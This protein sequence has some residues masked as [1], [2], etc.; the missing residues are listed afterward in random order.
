MLYRWIYD[1]LLVRTDPEIA[2]DVAMNAI[3]VFGRSPLAR[4]SEATVGYRGGGSFSGILSRPVPGRLG[5]AAGQDKDAQAILG[6]LALGFGFTEI[7]TITPLPQPGNE[8][9]RLWRVPKESAFRNR[10]G[11]N[12]LGADAAA[13]QLAVLRST[14]RGRAAIVGVNIGKNKWTEPEDAPRDYATCAQKLAR[15]AD[16]LV[17]NVSSPNTPGLRDLQAVGSLREI[18]SATREGARRATD[19]H[20]PI[21]VK[22]APDLAREDVRDVAQMV[23]DENLDGVVASN[24]T[25]AHSYG[26]G[27]L[28]GAPLLDRAVETVSYLRSRL[29]PDKIIIG[30]GGIFDANGAHRMVGAGADLVEALTGFVYEGPFMPGRVNRALARTAG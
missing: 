28:S 20:V 29:G 12:N 4:L 6:T 3:G 14:K 19:R 24:T 25:I 30:V 8:Q 22:I 21:L 27:G 16:Y 2:H 15:Y 23:V 11:F 5:L 26:E 13:E 9:P 18:A 17:I 7:G 10:M 1:H